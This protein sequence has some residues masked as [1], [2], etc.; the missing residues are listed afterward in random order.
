[1]NQPLFRPHG[2]AD[3]RVQGQNIVSD[4]WAPWNLQQMAA[5]G[6]AYEVVAIELSK[7]GPT[8]AVSQFHGSVLTSPESLALL[9]KMAEYS[10]K[11]HRLTATALVVMPE[12]EGALL[13][14]SIFTPIYEGLVQFRIVQDL[15]AGMEFAQAC[16]D[17][18]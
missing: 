5:W 2:H 10:V 8:A 11:A 3:I 14:K 18:A 15:D 12:V 1:M 7:A 9:R 17:A 16:L 13:A 6:K 4:I